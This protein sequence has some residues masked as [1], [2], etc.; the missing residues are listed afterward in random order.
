M[1]CDT[2]VT[3][4]GM[5]STEWALLVLEKVAPPPPILE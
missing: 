1:G 3:A 5:L 2:Y 4:L